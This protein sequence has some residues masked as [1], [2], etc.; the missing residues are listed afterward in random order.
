MN[1]FDDLISDDLEAPSSKP[2]DPPVYR[3]TCKKC[4]GSGRYNAPSSLGHNRCTTCG[5]KGFHEYKR[6]EA[7]RHA[8]RDR[9]FAR[10]ERV[11]RD[12]Q[13]DIAAKRA[14]WLVQ[15][16]AEASW[17][18]RNRGRSNFAAAMEQTL[19][20][21]GDLSPNKLAAVQRILA[22]DAVRN[23]ERQAREADAPT[24]NTS[25]IEAAFEKAN[26]LLRWPKLRLANYIFKPAPASSRN[27]GSLY[28][29]RCASDDQEQEYLGRITAGKLIASRDATPEDVARIQELAASPREAAE[30]YGRL[31]G[32]C[33]ICARPLSRADS[34]NR[35][36]G[37]IC[38]ER[39]GWI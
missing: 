32:N 5:G 34:V 13:S 36:I 39:F 15:F 14:A 26:K 9:R 6:S 16:P 21:F 30:K 23:Q 33:A 19:Q 1:D 18:E 29:K 8:A 24:V 12:R 17:I 10:K 28:V 27:A 2:V 3:E 31:T 7:E 20:T 22:E 11:E 35:G 4:G 25:Q 37:P 38:A